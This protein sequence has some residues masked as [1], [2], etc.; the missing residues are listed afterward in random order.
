MPRAPLWSSLLLTI[1]V[2]IGCGSSTPQDA[3]AKTEAAP[4]AAQAQP[5]QP[6]PSGTAVIQGTVTFTGTAPEPMVVQMA[7][8]P[9]CQQ[10]H[11]EPVTSEEVAINPNGSLRNVVV[12]IKEGVQG[13]Y[14]PPA[15]PVVLDQQGCWYHPHVMGIQVSQPLEIVNSDATLHNV[16]AKPSQN[17]PF[18]IAQ[19]V[20]GMK[21]KKSFAKPEVGVKFKCNVHPWMSAYA[22]VV[23]HPF[24]AVTGEDGSFRLTGLPA[25]TYTV[26]AWH[27]KYGPQQQTVTIGEGEMKT[28]T[29]GYQGG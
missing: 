26:E 14:P 29:F 20:K 2:A 10:Q 18:N 21:S 1:A 16:N 7:A 8:D 3:A 6:G 9:V 15:S 12:Y 4:A 23:P 27:E 24:F 11:S 25:G 22:V 19:P 28:V 13:A 5:V 17:Q